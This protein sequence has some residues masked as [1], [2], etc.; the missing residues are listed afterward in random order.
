MK[1]TLQFSYVIFNWSRY[2]SIIVLPISC[3]DLEVTTRNSTWILFF[4]WKDRY[5]TWSHSNKLIEY[6]DMSVELYKVTFIFF[7]SYIFIYSY[8]HILVYS[9]LGY[10]LAE[11]RVW[12]NYFL[13]FHTSTL[14]IVWSTVGN[15][16][17][18]TK[19]A[20]IYI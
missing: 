1:F 19:T 16:N 4:Y 13:S 7:F 5:A 6:D 8:F 18:V 11:I 20:S 10:Q 3:G 17:M 12:G 15:F 14:T 2:F 9:Y